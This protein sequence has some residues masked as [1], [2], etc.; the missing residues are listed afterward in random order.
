R[1]P[2]ERGGPTEGR[3]GGGAIPGTTS[4]TSQG[5]TA[6]RSRDR[7]RGGTEGS[8]RGTRRSVVGLPLCLPNPARRARGEGS[9]ADDIPSKGVRRGFRRPHVLRT[10]IP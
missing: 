3:R 5:R 9:P 4:S 10:G 8:R 2:G 1:A 7:L 6:R